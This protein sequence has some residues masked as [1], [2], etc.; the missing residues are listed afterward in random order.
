M[1]LL[2]YDRLGV[3]TVNPI[4]WPQVPFNEPPKTPE[5]SKPLFTI[6]ESET[7][8][9]MRDGVRLAADIYRPSTYGQKFPALLAT[10]PYSRQIQRSMVP[11][12]QN[13]SGITQ[14][15]VPRGYAHVVVD[16]RGSNDSEGSWDM[17]GP[18][19]QQDLFD[20]VE[21]IAEQPWCDGNVGM[22]GASYFSRSQLAA[23]TQQPPHLRAIFA[24]EASTDRYR[25][26]F[27]HGGILSSQW[28]R[29]WFDRVW[30]H[31]NRGDQLKDPSGIAR[32]SSIILGQELPFDGPYYQERGTFFKLDQIKI[33]AYFSCEWA[34]INLHLRGA[35]AGWERVNSPKRMFISPRATPPRPMGAF[36]V[37]ALR[38]YDYHLKGMDTGVMEGPPIQLYVQGLD[39][40]RREEEWPLARTQWR[41]FFLAGGK[42][43]E[44]SGADSEASYNYDP[45]SREAIF[46]KPELVYRTEPLGQ[47]LE[48]TGPLA[49]YLWA[50]STATDTDWLVTFNDEGPEG[51]VHE[52]C[53]GWLRA[54]HRELDNKLSKPY[55]PFHP[56]TRSELLIPNEAYEFAIYPN[57]LNSIPPVRCFIMNSQSY[58]TPSPR[59]SGTSTQPF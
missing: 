15:W 25:D 53:R 1:S 52:L 8:I 43:V 54:S 22:T 49:L 26:S 58:S 4:T 28:A 7:L 46:G 17:W 27:F 14:F 21:W 19:E 42:L 33:P 32:H 59:P 9:P 50:T 29:A 2:S 23:A 16:V 20:L 51:G 13:E 12:A 5:Q 47:D 40:W 36:H 41:E 44:T 35:F 24:F 31:S 37:E 11:N 39:R 55:Q 18:M 10:S 45:A 6:D 30:R 48:V 34:L 3:K 38:W 57:Y 56:H